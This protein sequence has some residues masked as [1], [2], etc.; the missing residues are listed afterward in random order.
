MD[1]T[2]KPFA[3]SNGRRVLSALR[4][5]TVLTVA[6]LAILGLA[7]GLRLYGLDWDQG[8][9]YTP[10]PDERAILSKVDEL[11]PPALGRLGLLLD[12]D[13]S[14]WN[15]RFFNYGSFPLYLLKG[16]Q[17][18]HSLGPGDE[19][20]DLRLAGRAIS[21]VADVATVMLVFLLG[22]RVYGRRVGALAAAL[23]AL[24]V[25]HIQLSHFFAVDTLLALFT[26]VA[27]YFMSRS[28]GRE[29]SGT[30]CWLG[31]SWVWV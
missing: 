19:L 20:R 27:V 1:V 28:P 11:S 17:L 10:H 2:Q 9:P 21:A 13:E 24:A 30:R 7:L 14:P 8:Y 22:A 25:L 31:S 16:V 23:A 15:P 6:V 18:V 4:I 29:G 26:V 12:A 3:L 5:E